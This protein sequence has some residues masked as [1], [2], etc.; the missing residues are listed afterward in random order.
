MFCNLFDNWFEKKKQSHTSGRMAS[1]KP[2]WLAMWWRATTT[3]S[4]FHTTNCR[5]WFLCASWSRK[6]SRTTRKFACCFLTF[7]T[8]RRV[9]WT[10]LVDSIS[11]RIRWI[12]TAQTTKPARLLFLCLDFWLVRFQRFSK[13]ISDGFF[14]LLFYFRPRGITK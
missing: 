2:R 6:L 12:C 14:F 10:M 9:V 7:S 1:T 4:R 8:V 11:M 3:T 13:V 5:G